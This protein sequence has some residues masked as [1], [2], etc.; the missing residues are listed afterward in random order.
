MSDTFLGKIF[1][2]LTDEQQAQ[3]L[4]ETGRTLRRVCH[5]HASG[6]DMQLCMIIDHLDID[7][8]RFIRKLA[9]FLESDERPR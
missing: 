7:G 9:E 2:L 5:E 4:N 8:K 3:F 1:A 6:E